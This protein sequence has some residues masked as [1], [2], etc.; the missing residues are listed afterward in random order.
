MK[1]ED[2]KNDI[3]IFDVDGVLGKFD[4]GELGF[5]ILEKEEWLKFN[6]ECD[7]YAYVQKT[8]FFD[9]FIKKHPYVMALSVACCS[10]EQDN[11]VRFILKNYPTIQREDI[12]FVSEDCL[13][14]EVLKQ[15]R[16]NLDKAGLHNKRLVLIEDTSR[17]MG[18]VEKLKNEKIKCFLLSDFL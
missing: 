8:S 6:M 1:L 4:F 18:S 15:L 10:F 12:M 11:K 17:I 2:L 13:K 3:V 7:A 16:I 5:K 9:E 14:V